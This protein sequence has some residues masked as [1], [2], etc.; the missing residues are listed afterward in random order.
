[1][2]KATS[3]NF[4]PGVLLAAMANAQAVPAKAQVSIDIAKVTCEQFWLRKVPEP[5]KIA[6]WLSGYFHGKAGN[7]VVDVQHFQQMS[8]KVTDHCRTNFHLTLMQAAQA[9]A[10]EQK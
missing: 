6:I 3:R 8:A 5:E 4:L 1:M 7:T 2:F 10:A 9:I